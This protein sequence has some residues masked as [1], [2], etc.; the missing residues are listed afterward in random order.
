MPKVRWKQTKCSKNFDS[1]RKELQD[2]CHCAWLLLKITWTCPIW[3]PEKMVENLNRSPCFVKFCWFGAADLDCWGCCWFQRK[4]CIFWLACLACGFRAD[5]RTLLHTWSCWEGKFIPVAWQ[6]HWKT[7]IRPQCYS[8]RP[9]AVIGKNQPLCWPLSSCS[10]V[11][12]SKFVVV[13]G[14]VPPRRVLLVSSWPM[15]ACCVSFA[16]FIL[17]E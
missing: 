3:Q 15:V 11:H 4:T 10:L 9:E 7:S 13:C 5:E 14:G 6:R 2:E 8:C 1:L 12:S 16:G 17:E